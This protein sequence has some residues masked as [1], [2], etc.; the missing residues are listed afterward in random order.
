M[1]HQLNIGLHVLSGTI[2]LILGVL[3][4]ALNQR[5]G[6]HRKLGTLFLYFLGI[7][8]V[9]GF[10]GWLLFRSDPF[11]L[12]LTVLAGYEG[13]AGVRIIK[14][15]EKHPTV[16]DLSVAVAALLI[17][18]SYVL[19]LS[20]TAPGMS[21]SVVKSTLVALTIVTTYDIVK[22]LFIYRYVKRWW[23][24]EHI[25][26][27]ISAFSAIL[28]AFVGTVVEGFRPYSQLGPSVVCIWLIVFFIWRRAKMGRTG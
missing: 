13:F 7:V 9:S 10:V 14:T 27:M 23:L 19:W 25:Y 1:F 26:K 17:G 15:R 4:I 24:Y 22:C 28:S 2:A 12:L 6:I 16:L 18:V 5:P 11:L 20:A 3:A 8:V 21:S